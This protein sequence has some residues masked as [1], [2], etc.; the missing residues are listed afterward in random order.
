MSA[1][2]LWRSALDF[3]APEK[4]FVSA[5][6]ALRFQ[7]QGSPFSSLTSLHPAP[8][9]TAQ[10][11]TTSQTAAKPKRSA[12]ARRRGAQAIAFVQVR[13]PP[14]PPPPARA[15]TPSRG[16]SRSRGRNRRSH[17]RT[18]R[19][20]HPRRDPTHHRRRLRSHLLRRL[21]RRLLHRHLRSSRPVRERARATRTTCTP[22]RL[23]NRRRRARRESR[24][25]GGPRAAAEVLGGVLRE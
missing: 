12:P 3:P 11:G 23:G 20:H 19:L 18:H 7:L 2:Y 24:G 16:R 9:P 1:G 14:P 8:V 5:Q 4:V 25:L 17:G 21:S 13:P 22:A 6:P 10:P 15:A